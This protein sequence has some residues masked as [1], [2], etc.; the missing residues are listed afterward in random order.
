MDLPYHSFVWPSALRGKIL[1]VGHC[2]QTFPLF[3]FL[4]TMLGRKTE[5]GKKERSNKQG[6]GE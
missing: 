3:S 1:H 5:E 6:K 4:S 2:D